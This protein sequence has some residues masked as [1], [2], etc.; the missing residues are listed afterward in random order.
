MD[1]ISLGLLLTAIGVVLTALALALT[2]FSKIPRRLE[3]L[4]HTVIQVGKKQQDESLKYAEERQAELAKYAEQAKQRSEHLK[5]LLNDIRTR[6]LTPG[7][8]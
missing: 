7:G 4:Y 5:N 6:L 3:E 8:P 2:I 1:A